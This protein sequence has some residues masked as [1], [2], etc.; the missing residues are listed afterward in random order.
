MLEL[1]RR[2]MVGATTI[3]IFDDEFKVATF[4][5]LTVEDI[6]GVGRIKPVAA[7]HFA[8]QAELVQNLTNLTGS[9][10]WQTVAPHFSGVKL[11]QIL[12]EIFDLKDYEVVTPFVMLSEQADAQRQQMALQENIQREMSTATGQGKDFDLEELNKIGK[13]PPAQTEFNLKRQP[14]ASAEPG[15]MLATQ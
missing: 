2:N 5:T 7:R 11:A 15:G 9:A 8:E 4:Q 3:R 13:K 10:L 1:A 6:T 12:E 14:P